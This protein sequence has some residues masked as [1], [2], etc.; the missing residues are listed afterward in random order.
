MR[1]NG[2]VN[3]AMSTVQ[4]ITDVMASVMGPMTS[5]IESSIEAA[6]AVKGNTK[7]AHSARLAA[8]RRFMKSWVR[9]GAI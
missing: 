7:G 1:T 6:A 2:T 4:K 3:P 8:I 9:W 5:L